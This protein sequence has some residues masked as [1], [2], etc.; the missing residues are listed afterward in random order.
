VVELSLPSLAAPQDSYC[1]L[2]VEVRALDVLAGRFVTLQTELS[3]SRPAE[4][5]N[6]RQGN[7]R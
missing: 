4:L 1:P 2:K 3:V 5:P 6:D 7:N